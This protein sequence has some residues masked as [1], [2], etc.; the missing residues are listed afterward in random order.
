MS[1]VVSGRMANFT[2]TGHLSAQMERRIQATGIKANN[3]VQVKKFGL[4]APTMR[5]VSS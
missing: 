2:A 1:T 4:M 3:L 5:V